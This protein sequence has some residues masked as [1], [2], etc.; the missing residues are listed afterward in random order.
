MKENILSVV[1]ACPIT[2]TQNLQ[3]NHTFL[4]VLHKLKDLVAVEISSRTSQPAMHGFL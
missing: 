3:K 2:Y 1:P 4:T